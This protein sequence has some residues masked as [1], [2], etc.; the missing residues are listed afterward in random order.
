MEE[1]LTSEPKEITRIP[2]SESIWFFDI[3]DTLIDTAGTTLAASDAIRDTLKAKIGQDKAKQIQNNFNQIFN[4]M[5]SGHQATEGHDSGEYDKLLLQMEACQS[6]IK[7]RYGAIKKWSR[8]V[9][10][11][12]AADNAGIELTPALIRYAADAYWQSL[13]EKTKLFPGVENLMELI[14]NHNRPVFLITSSDARLQMDESGQFDYDP[15]YSEGLKR[16]RIESLGQKGI[17]FNAISIGDPQDK[18]HLDFFEKGIKVAEADLGH[19]VDFPNAIMVGDS[20]T[21]DLQVPKEHFGFGLTVLF[22][23]DSYDTDIKDT[24][25]LNTGN[26][27]QVANFLT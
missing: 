3:D 26:L 8:E 17:T 27:Q 22:K 15:Q 6:K 4:L 13:T 11:K 10:I 12:I 21:G 25:Q 5:L 2:W 9:F 24:H 18:P 20:Y 14:Q 16:Q 19:P 23:K 1:K 7:E